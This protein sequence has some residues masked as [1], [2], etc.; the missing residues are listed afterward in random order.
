MGNM[1]NRLDRVERHGNEAGTTTQDVRKVGAEPRAN[2]GSRAERPRW[3][4]YEDFEVDVNDIGDGG[5]KDETIS[6]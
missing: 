5:F 4:N 1:C 2:N 6:H 3:A